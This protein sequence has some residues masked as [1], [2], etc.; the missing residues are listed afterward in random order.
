MLPQHTLSFHTSDA[1]SRLPANGAR[2]SVQE[3][4]FLSRTYATFECHLVKRMELPYSNTERSHRSRA[5]SDAH[6]TIFS[7]NI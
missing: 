1:F 5:S 4:A 2:R 7:E 6:N 3:A